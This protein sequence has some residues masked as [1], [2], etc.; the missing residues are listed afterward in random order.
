MGIGFYSMESYRMASDT[1]VVELTA[2]DI[3][4]IETQR[5]AIT[6]FDLYW[7]DGTSR[8][9]EVNGQ[10]VRSVVWSP[11]SRKIAVM[12]DWEGEDYG[13]YVYDIA[14]DDLQRVADT[15]HDLWYHVYY[16][17][18]SPD[19]EW[20]AVRGPD[21]YFIQRLSDGS[22]IRLDERL[23]GIRLYW[24]PVMEYSESQCDIE[25]GP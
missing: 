15:Y 16:P 9:V 10:F 17:S 23:T 8:H 13:V 6:G 1:R 20:L 22:R 14:A 19:E 25:T 24:S 2:A 21:R 5:P 18:W 11:T 7:L 3:A 4:E 12:T